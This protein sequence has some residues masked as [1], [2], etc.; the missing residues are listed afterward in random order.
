[1]GAGKGKAEIRMSQSLKGG[2]DMGQV[3]LAQRT[4]EAAPAKALAS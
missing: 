3:V 4:S 2:M 1:M